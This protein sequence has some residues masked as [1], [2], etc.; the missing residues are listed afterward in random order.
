MS[1]PT[2][3]GRRKVGDSGEEDGG[4]ELGGGGAGDG[5]RWKGDGGADK[6]DKKRHS[7]EKNDSYKFGGEFAI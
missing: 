3:I 4:I 6:K 2:V 7:G 1:H 5:G